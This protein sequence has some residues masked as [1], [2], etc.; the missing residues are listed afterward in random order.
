MFDGWLTVEGDGSWCVSSPTPPPLLSPGDFCKIQNQNLKQMDSEVL[1]AEVPSVVQ[2]D[3][4]PLGRAGMQVHSPAWHSGL[5]FQSFHSCGLGQ[6]RG[7]N[8]IPGLGTPCAMGWPKKKKKKKK[9][10]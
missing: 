6:D 2:Q 7:L 3:W 5:S 4:W 9:P 8:L 1:L 10:K